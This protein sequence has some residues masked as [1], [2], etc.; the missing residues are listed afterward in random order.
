[1]ATDIHNP[2]NYIVDSVFCMCGFVDDY[3]TVICPHEPCYKRHVYVCS[4]IVNFGYCYDKHCPCSMLS[5][6][7]RERYL[8]YS[9]KN[10]NMDKIGFIISNTPYRKSISKDMLKIMRKTLRNSLA[11]K[12]LP[13]PYLSGVDFFEPKIK[14]QKIKKQP[15]AVYF[16][17][18]PPLSIPCPPTLSATSSPTTS[19]PPFNDNDNPSNLLNNNTNDENSLFAY[20]LFHLI[21]FGQPDTKN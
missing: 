7:A 15:N 6:V 11:I 18:D 2:H 8:Y 14:K 16:S 3:G 10:V 5:D 17:P 12:S 1:M 13:I 21:L 4:N 20:E 19:P 9:K